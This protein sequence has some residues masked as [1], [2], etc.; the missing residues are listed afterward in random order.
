MFLA[1]IM[2][3]GSP[4]DMSVNAAGESKP[5]ET[6]ASGFDA[7]RAPVLSGPVQTWIYKGDTFDYEDSRNKVFADDQEDGDLTKS[8]IQEGSVDTSKLGDQTITY[9]VTDSDGN[10]TSHQTTV[11]V[12]EKDSTDASKKNIKRELYT[13]PNA[14]HL[15]NIGFGRGYDHDRQNLGFWLPANETLTIR[16]VNHDEFNDALTLKLLNNDAYTE[17]LVFMEK[18]GTESAYDD[19]RSSV[20]LPGNGDW[21]TVKNK[22][23]VQDKAGNKTTEL[24]SVDSVPFIYT[25][26]NTTVKPIIE[27]KW[28][29]ALHSIPYYRYGDDEEAFFAGWDKSNAPYGIIEGDAAT[30]LVPVKD[31]KHIIHYQDAKYPSYSFGTIDEMLEWYASFVK[32]YDKFS[33]LDFYAK[34]PYNQNVRAKFFIKAN[35]HGVGFAY[36]SNDHSATNQD[37]L[38]AYLCKA[39]V[40]LHEFGHGYEGAIARQENS[41]VETT[42]NIMGY[43][44]EKLYR[45]EEDLGWLLEG[46]GATYLDAFNTIGKAAEKLRNN[47]NTFNDITE[48]Q[49]EYDKSLFMFV[50]LLDRIGPEQAVAAM[51]TD[52]RK[53]YDENQKHK[54]SS[55]TLTE[56]FSESGGFNVIPYFEGW[57]I[58][59]SEILEDEIYDSDLPMLYYL[60]NLIPNDTEAET[61]R[62]QLAKKG[63]TMNG[64]Y[65][66]VSTDDLAEFHYKSNVKLS[67]S[68]D[69][70][71]KVKGKKILIKNGE[72]IAAELTIQEDKKEYQLELPVGIYEVELPTPRDGGYQYNNEYLVAYKT[73]SNEF[74]NKELAYHKI[75]G[76][77]LVDD[78][79]IRLLGMAD[80]E[81]A[82]LSLD[83]AKE[84]I[85]FRINNTE[86][87]MYFPNQT[88]ITVRILDPQGKELEKKS[89]SGT[90]KQPIF[91]KQYNFPIN[92][93]LEISYINLN[94]LGRMRFTS[95]YTKNVLSAFAV[96]NPEMDETTGMVKATFVMTDKGLMRDSWDNEQQDFAYYSMMASYSDYLLSHMQ[97]DDLEI[98]SHFHNAKQILSTAYAHLNQ[99]DQ[100]VY[101]RAYG[102][103]IGHEQTI[104]GYEKVKGLT[105][106]ADSH[107]SGEGPEKA[108][109]DDPNTY[110]HSNWNGHIINDHQNN[111]T[112][113][114]SENT[115]I[116]KLEYVPR[117]SGGSNGI[118]LTCDISYST[119]TDGDNFTK[120]LEN[121]KWA[122]DKTM[123]S[124][125]FEAPN[126][127]R[128]RITVLS[129]AG[130]GNS[131]FASAAEFYLYSKYEKENPENYLSDLNLGTWSG[132]KKDTSTK[133]VTIPAGTNVTADLTG[134]EF[135]T[136]TSKVNVTGNGTLT[137]S[138]DGKQLYHFDTETGDTQDAFSMDLAGIHR[139]EFRTSG[140][141]QIILSKARFGNQNNKKDLFLV[142]NDKATG[143]GN[144]TLTQAGNDKLNWTSGN[145]TVATV[146]DWGVITAKG[147]GQTVVKALKEDGTEVMA[148]NV[149]VKSSVKEISDALDIIKQDNKTELEA[150]T[151]ANNYDNDGKTK[152]TAAI[153]EGK[154]AIDAAMNISG[155]QAA[156][157]HAKEQL[158][159][160]PTKQDQ[161]AAQLNEKKAEAKAALEA[162]K[163][164][165]DYRH[166]EK[167]ELKRAI[168]EGKLAIEQATSIAGVETALA[169]AKTKLDQIKTDAQL[170]DETVD[171]EKHKLSEVLSEVEQRISN[172]DEKDYAPANW[173]RLQDAIKEA[174]RVTALTANETS[175]QEITEVKQELLAAE[176]GLGKPETVREAEAKLQALI[177]QCVQLKE[178]D[179]TK[180]S[181]AAYWD[182]LEEAKTYLPGQPNEQYEG[183]GAILIKAATD[184]LLKQKEA[185]VLN[186][187]PEIYEDDWIKGLL[188]ASSGMQIADKTLTLTGAGYLNSPATFYSMETFDFTKDGEFEFDL[189]YTG[190][191]ARFGV[192]LDYKEADNNAYGMYMGF[193]D[194]GWYWQRFDGTNDYYHGDRISAPEDQAETHVKVTWTAD[195]KYSLFVNEQMA[196]EKVVGAGNYSTN[197]R[198]AFSCT[199]GATAK[200]SRIKPSK[201]RLRIS[202]T[203]VE[204]FTAKDPVKLNLLFRNETDKKSEITWIS[205]NPQVAYVDKTGTVRF[206]GTGTAEITATVTFPDGIQQAVTS[207]VNLPDRIDEEAKFT[208]A[209][210]NTEQSGKAP[211]P[212]DGPA[213]YA[214]DKNEDTKWHSQYDGDRFT[215]SEDHPAL[216][217][218]GF[219]RDL[220]LCTEIKF[221]QT[222]A[223]SNGHVNGYQ[224][225]A[226]DQY[227][228]EAYEIEQNPVSGIEKTVTEI[229]TNPPEQNRWVT[230]TLPE[231]ADPDGRLGHY[232]QL[233][234]VN[235]QNDYAVIQ[236]ITAHFT[237]EIAS[238]EVE[239]GYLAANQE[240]LTAIT[241]LETLIETAEKADPKDYLEEDWQVL[242]NAIADAKA[243]M[244]NCTSTA[245][246]EAAKAALQEALDHRTIQ[247]I[248]TFHWNYDGANVI[249]QYVVS[250]NSAQAVTEAPDR[251]GYKFTGKWYTEAACK[252]EYDFS[253][254]TVTGDITLY[255]GWEL[256]QTGGNDEDEAEKKAKEKAKQDLKAA[257]SSAKPLIKAGQG[258]YTKTTWNAF[259]KAYNDVKNL[260]EEQKEAMTA[261]ELQSLANALKKAQKALKK[262]PA[263]I[264]KL[265]FNAKKYQIA[266]G[267]SINLKN[268]LEIVP[269]K[270]SNQKLV[271]KISN[272]KY[273]KITSKGVVKPLKKGANKKVVVTVS[274]T[275]GKVTA[276]TT[277]HIMK[278]SVSKITAKSS[279]SIKSKANKSITLKTKVTTKGGKPVNQ[280]LK[281]TSS[282]TKIATVKGSGKTAASAKVKIAKG[283]KKG[284]TVKITAASTD[285][286]GKKV[287]FK[288][289]IK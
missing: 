261:K 251:P 265:I 248:V 252:N 4:P 159:A 42:N 23:Y 12:L 64:I 120:V 215:V 24:Q 186:L 244:E 161:T 143:F 197:G 26:K 132:V 52:V 282:N 157:E 33:G 162:Y 111:Y 256:S 176:K 113:T 242:Q 226:G 5:T 184:N 140:S 13:L 109:D 253:K 137:V 166:N 246:I 198:I 2:I 57:H 123:K 236:E 11:T 91:E 21:I 40:S 267:K 44:F 173:K 243:A 72:K 278:G 165:E 259:V 247:H 63:L 196:F 212:N 134:K 169:A 210:A 93:K 27:V 151:N 96:T 61:V 220:S 289:T 60:R 14:S 225:V 85:N 19:N 238:N 76:N 17:N 193:E 276:K 101:D 182:A 156:L 53:Y 205:S 62:G 6:S 105:G 51:H 36:Y 136:F 50:N 285:G 181:W 245:E 99:K 131:Q 222:G 146:D 254:E 171:I 38:A 34:E 71:T 199:S 228:K 188:S 219:E 35:K 139:L 206:I 149:Y 277:V 65:S 55:D 153:A 88:Y 78:A 177:D 112:I 107:Q 46:K 167:V 29:D 194:G 141:G 80:V 255:A 94:E 155:I 249:T 224:L 74:V 116:G 104:Y 115:D 145:A 7:Y 83:T 45:E 209:W 31:K 121:T 15:T 200:I 73:G 54:P 8:I 118:I 41:F 175:I 250:G 227:N 49:K 191:G 221:L 273:A 82:A 257:Q 28:N 106:T 87:H 92:S 66:L 9:K 58:R 124:A 103:L 281:W 126:A 234:V 214:I 279:K 216:L 114:L 274:T 230:L 168:A 152:R 283:V 275:N 260:T 86:P 229:V 142:Q 258:K 108:L 67:L 213:T 129:S 110:W 144:L 98:E 187:P 30:F 201:S 77:P 218:V 81:V 164:P 203:N 263:S 16:L 208:G 47:V 183:S 158:D 102:R 59:P 231:S 172:L 232:L 288:I 148:C 133:T 178:E 240:M 135:D 170:G 25:P 185:L 43:Y 97:M 235:G 266:Y 160:I 154:T 39:W 239:Q 287:V 138:G 264:T 68:M 89:L 217:T 271:W 84:K 122:D 190:K 150:Y 95:Q 90:G 117:Q 75:E 37:S 189:Q 128:I 280:T 20:N 56:I 272:P 70:I 3:V 202:P 179:Y 79:Q 147:T 18:D 207:T 22:C 69:D 100:D 130:G 195:G 48:G 233:R 237:K 1:A 32:Q 127:R 119:D 163:N 286:T 174:R 284:K 204:V 270:Y 268:E 192:Y 125:E 241:A 269:K 180:E 223:G 262:E 10:T 211:Y